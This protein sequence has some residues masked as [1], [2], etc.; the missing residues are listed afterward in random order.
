MASLGGGSGRQVVAGVLGAVGGLLAGKYLNTPDITFREE[1]AREA[2]PTRSLAGPGLQTTA[3][4]AQ[5]LAWGA[6]RAPVGPGPLVYSNHVLEYDAGRKVPRWVAE[7]LTRATVGQEVASRKGV[8]FARDPAVPALFSSDNSDYWGSGWSRGH[9][10]PAGDN[11]HCQ[12]SMRDTFYLTNIVPQDMDNNGGYWN[13]L[14]IWCRNLTKTYSDVWVISGPLWLPDP[15]TGG[16][17]SDVS[18]DGDKRPRKKRSEVRTVQ[19]KVLGDNLVSVPTH[20]FKVVLVQD[21]GMSRPLLATFVVPNLPIADQHLTTYKT[22]L[23]ELERHVGVVFHPELDRAS[24]GDLCVDSGCEL[25]DY[26]QFMQFFWSRRLRSP[27]NLTNL[28]RD[29]AEV[30]S[31]GAENEELE[32]IYNEAKHTLM[33]KEKEKVENSPKP[34]VASVG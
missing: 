15:L 9:M 24:A 5:I 14:E 34:I 19:Y 7:H 31:K 8:S 32:K 6:P 30:V 18:S 17:E 16:S 22:S 27:W 3:R 28:E 4:A 29:W 21:P 20:L 10:A 1:A 12:Q 2:L 11:K 26:K 13:R 23:E 33:A 25:Q